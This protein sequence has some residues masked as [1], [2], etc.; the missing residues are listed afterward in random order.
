MAVRSPELG[1]VW[2]ATV[3]RS[4]GLVRIVEEGSVN[5]LLGFWP[6]DRA[7]DERTEEGELQ[8]GRGNSGEEYR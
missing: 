6:R 8:A 3:P 5:K 1:R 7:R 2:A 4:P